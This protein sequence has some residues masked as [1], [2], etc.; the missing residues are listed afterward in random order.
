[1]SLDDLIVPCEQECQHGMRCDRARS[2]HDMPHS[3]WDWQAEG[4]I[5]EWDDDTDV[6]MIMLP[7]PIDVWPHCRVLSE[8][9]R[10]QMPWADY[11]E[12]KIEDVDLP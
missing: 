4:D 10:K 7:L 11:D 5:H 3:G 2:D 9:E 6:C 12:P 1:M 8:D